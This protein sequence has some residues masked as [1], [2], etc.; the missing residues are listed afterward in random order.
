VRH[1]M[2]PPAAAAGEQQV[3][4]L[5]SGREGRRKDLGTGMKEAAEI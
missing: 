3:A 2:K 4:A 5:E 1:G